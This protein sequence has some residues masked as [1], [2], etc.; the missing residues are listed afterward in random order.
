MIVPLTPNDVNHIWLVAETHFTA[1][2][3]RQHLEKYP[4]LGWVI[5]ENGDY[6][7]G[8]YWKD[9]PAIGLIM[10]SSPSAQRTELVNRLL[11]SYKETRSD[12]V[13]LSEREVSH[14]LRLYLDM[15]F[16]ALEQVICYEKPDVYVPYTPRRLTVRR[17]QESDLLAL[18][19]L[20]RAAFPWLWWE[21]ATT[22]Q[23]TDRRPDTWVLVAY[24]EDQLVG[25]LILTVRGPWGHLNRI[26]VHPTYQGQG[27]GRELLAVA[28][29]EMSRRGARTIGLNTQIDNT[30]SQRLYEGFGFERTGE[31]FKIYGK[32]LDDRAQ[33]MRS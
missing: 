23:Q 30:R 28:I 7:V 22:F 25:Y 13:V 15:G 21:T 3:L 33:G 14:G 20:E 18:V 9:R 4:Y 19:E 11:E 27:F 24:L 6:I 31:T 10:E 12:L 26:G 8:G 32:W 2:L 5:K 29:E 17:L 16:V 1:R